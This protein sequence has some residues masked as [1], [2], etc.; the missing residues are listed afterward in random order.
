MEGISKNDVREI[1][2]YFNNCNITKQEL[3]YQLYS[4]CKELDPWLPIE[5]APKEGVFL[6]YLPNEKLKIQ[7]AKFHPNINVIGNSFAF[8]LTEPTHY[9]PLPPDPKD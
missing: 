6:V 5:N 7:A 2:N 9:K 8:D 1:I 4:R 3:S